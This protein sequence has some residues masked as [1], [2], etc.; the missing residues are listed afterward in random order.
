MWFLE[1]KNST[2]V[3]ISNFY[4]NVNDMIYFPEKSKEF[5]WVS[6][7]S[8]YYH[9]YRYNYDG[10]IINQVTKGNWGL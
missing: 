4:T 1:E 6:D 10:K 9:I 3:A 2:W 8:G 7:R 5:F